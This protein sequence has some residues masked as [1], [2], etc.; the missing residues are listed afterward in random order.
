MINYY[1]QVK[2]VLSFAPESVLEIG[3]GDSLVTNILKMSVPSV[4]TCDIDAALKPDFV[5]SVVKLPFKDEEFDVVLCSEVLE[6]IKFEEAQEALKEIYRSSK[7]GA[8]IGVPHA[9]AVLSLN[10]KL[11]LLPRIKIFTKIPFFWKKHK[12]NGEHYWETGKSG[13]FRAKLRQSIKDCGFIITSEEIAQDDPSHL[14]FV[15]SKTGSVDSKDVRKYYN[16]TVK[17]KYKGNYE[18]ARWFSNP[19]KQ[20]GYHMTKYV[21]DNFVVKTIKKSSSSQSKV[22]ELGPG[23]GTWSKVLV[24]SLPKSKFDLVDISKEMLDNCRRTLADAGLNAE[25]VSFFEENFIDWQTKEKYDLFFSS[26]VIEYFP[27]KRILAEKIYSL[28]NSGAQGY[29]ITKTPKY[30]FDRIRGRAEQAFHSGQ[31][32]PKHFKEILMRAGFSDVEIRPVTFSFPL[33]SSA[34]LNM[35]LHKIFRC[36]SLNTPLS[37]LTE[38]YLVSFRKS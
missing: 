29:I 30:L 23:A 3:V 9:G 13:N 24:E 38:S 10:L 34:P 33:A 26:R 16:S 19:L 14:I 22:L 25:N 5:A 36:S 17:D 20:A 18:H 11:P 15:C 35:F 8:V 6:H 28:M 37:Y 2:S 1:R 27:D 32:K 31:I 21:V 12:F 4:T 7:K